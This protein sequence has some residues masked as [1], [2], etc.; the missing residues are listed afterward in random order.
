MSGATQAV[1]WREWWARM[2]ESSDTGMWNET[3]GVRSR[4]LTPMHAMAAKKLNP[5]HSVTD[6]QTH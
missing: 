1:V 4:R 6:T 2:V 5:V 3:G